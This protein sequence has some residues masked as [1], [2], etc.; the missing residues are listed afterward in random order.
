MHLCTLMFWMKSMNHECIDQLLSFTF[1]VTCTCTPGA[2]Y[3][4]TLQY[5]LYS[6]EIYANISNVMFILKK[7]ITPN[8]KLLFM[9]SPK[10]TN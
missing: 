10:P 5:I 1:F 8:E 4:N 2:F 7:L 6:V 9:R 3:A